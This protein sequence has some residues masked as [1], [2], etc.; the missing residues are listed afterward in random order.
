M[1]T[2]RVEMS[3]L[4]LKWGLGGC[5]GGKRLSSGLSLFYSKIQTIWMDDPPNH[6]VVGDLNHL[7]KVVYIRGTKFST[8]SP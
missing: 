5:S 8:D 2:M 3:F 7:N 1:T 4:P 6:L